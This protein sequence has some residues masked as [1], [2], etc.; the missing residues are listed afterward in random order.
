MA[1]EI[2]PTATEDEAAAIAAAVSA[3]MHD[4]EKAATMGDNEEETWEGNQ[5]KFAARIQQTKHKSVRV[6]KTAPT[7]PWTAADRL[8]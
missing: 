7:D 3:H 1:L 6:P 8:E 5:W 2:T 4:Q